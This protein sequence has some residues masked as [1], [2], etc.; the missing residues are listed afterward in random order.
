MLLDTTCFWRTQLKLRSIFMAVLA[1]VGLAGLTL[2]R[3]AD[4]DLGRRASES[5]EFTTAGHLLTGTLWLPDEIPHAAIVLVHGDGA[6]DR[7]SFG[8]YAPLI[9]AFLDRGIAVAAWDKP[10]VGSSGGNWLL[11]SM[12]ERTDETRAALQLL[13]TRLE[14]VSVGAVGFSQAG[15]VLPGLSQSDADF[16]VLIGAAVS[17]QDQGRYYTRTRLAQEG[18]SP[19]EIDRTIADQDRENERIFGSDASVTDAPDNMLPDRWRFIQQNRSANSREEL[20]RFDIPIFAIW[21]AD[22]L[23][24]DAE[25]DSTI[26]RELLIEHDARTKILVWPDATHGLLRSTAYNW[27]L[28]EDWSWMAKLRFIAEGRHAF[29]PGAL[30]AIIDWIDAR[31]REDGSPQ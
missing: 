28:T 9:N 10:G 15:W 21:G 7:T 2:W 20:S 12:G 3:L 24:V 1:V 14:G 18:L 19:N 4:H 8:G 23:N 13:K 6:Q 30:G 17:W 5:F 27:Q 26:Y 29:A 16:L 31:S 22:D 11:Q 25:Q